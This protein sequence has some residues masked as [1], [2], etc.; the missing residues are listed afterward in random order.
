MLVAGALSCVLALFVFVHTANATPPIFEWYMYSCYTYEG[1]TDLPV[2]ENNYFLFQKYFVAGSPAYYYQTTDIW[3]PDWNYITGSDSY[4][5]WATSYS[6]YSFS[7]EANGEQR[8]CSGNAS[9]Y[10]HNNYTRSIDVYITIWADKY[11]TSGVYSGQLCEMKKV[12]LAAGYDTVANLWPY[13]L[14]NYKNATF[15]VDWYLSPPP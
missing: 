8:L 4:A 13:P 9:L 6:N 12:V 10:L 3:D 11:S 5:P 2:D 1:V 14:Y 15:Q 7:Y